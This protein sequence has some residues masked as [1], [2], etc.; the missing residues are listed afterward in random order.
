ME[1]L[2]IA[3]MQEQMNEMMDWR[4]TQMQQE[5][6][7]HIAAYIQENEF[8]P[9]EGGEGGDST[10]YRREEDGDDDEED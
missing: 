4:K 3:R 10:T 2:T 6:D 8:M 1:E 7:K 5:I 9:R